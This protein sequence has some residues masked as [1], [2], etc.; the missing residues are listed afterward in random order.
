M[1]E[2][3]SKDIPPEFSRVRI[4]DFKSLLWKDSDWLN[5]ALLDYDNDSM[6]ARRLRDERMHMLGQKKLSKVIL[7]HIEQIIG[8]D[9]PH[10]KPKTTRRTY[11]EIA[12]YSRW[13]LR[14]SQRKRAGLTNKEQEKQ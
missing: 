12:R 13:S 9:E 5:E 3:D 8:E 1:N 7:L 10:V 6:T 14:A 2:Q 4:K 11:A